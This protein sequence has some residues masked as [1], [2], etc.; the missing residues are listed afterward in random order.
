[1]AQAVKAERRAVNLHQSIKE[2]DMRTDLVLMT[3]I[4]GRVGV[5][6]EDFVDICTDAVT[7]RL[8][9]CVSLYL[10]T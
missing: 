2:I 8:L 1:M 9:F 6:L 10:G 5:G 7:L 3:G 4:R